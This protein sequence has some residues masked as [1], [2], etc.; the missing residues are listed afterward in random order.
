MLA[1]SLP[2]GYRRQVPPRAGAVHPRHRAHTWRRLSAPKK[3]RHT[4]Q[5]ISERLRDE[6]GF[7]GKY[8]IVKAYVRE[9]RRQSRE[10]F[11]PLSHTRRASTSATSARPGWSS[12]EQK[13]HY[14]VPNHWTTWTGSTEV[15][16]HSCA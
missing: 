15:S 9:R 11:V 5:S 10:M 4:A 6:H 8:T 3:Q 7:S 2:P 1:Y 13:A 14:F 12:A 16:V